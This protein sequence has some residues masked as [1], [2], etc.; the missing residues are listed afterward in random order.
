MSVV[1]WDL[2]SLT[3]ASVYDKEFLPKYDLTQSAKKKNNYTLA[4]LKRKK[5]PRFTRRDAETIMKVLTE[6]EHLICFNESHEITTM[7]Q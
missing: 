7:R 4:K 1:K 2:N 5:A 6:P 3:Y